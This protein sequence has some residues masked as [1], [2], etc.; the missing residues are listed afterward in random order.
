MTFFADKIFAVRTYNR[1]DGAAAKKGGAIW[2]GPHNARFPA[3]GCEACQVGLPLYEW[4]W[5]PPKFADRAVQLREIADE[6]ATAALAR[7]VER[8]AVSRA[9][10]ESVVATSEPGAPPDAL[11]AHEARA[12]EIRAIKLPVPEGLSYRP[13]QVAGTQFMLAADAGTI[14]GDEPGLGKTIQVI[15]LINAVGG[16]SLIV[17]PA[18]L[19]LNWLRECVRWLVEPKRIHVIG[20]ANILPRLKGST[21]PSIKVG[22]HRVSAGPTLPADICTDPQAIV[23]LNYDRA[24]DPELHE[25]LMACS[26]DTLAADEAH[27]LKTPKSLRTIA[28]LGREEKGELVQEGLRQRAG[29]FIAMTGTPLPN[30]P[31]E[32]WPILH[33]VAPKTFPSFFGFARRYCAA[34]KKY[35]SRRVGEKWDFTGSSNLDEL[36]NVMRSTCMVRR[37]K[38]DVLTELPPKI[39]TIIALPADDFVDLLGEGEDYEDRP[40]AW[41]D[42]ADWDDRPSREELDVADAAL[43]AIIEGEIERM[44]DKSPEAAYV[45]AAMLLGAGEKIDFK[46]MS[47]MREKLALRKLGAVLE[48]ADN[49]LEEEAKII[50]FAHHHS[51]VEKILD[52]YNPKPKKGKE[53]KVEA[54]AFYGP[55][56]ARDR[57]EAIQ[58]FQTDP[59]IRVFV[60]SIA[61][62]GVGITLTE[63]STVIF[64]EVSFVP[65]DIVQAEDRAHRIGQTKVVNVLHVVVE[66]S[67]DARMVQMLVKKAD[68]A[69]QA[70]DRQT[71]L[72]VP[73]AGLDVAGERK[74]KRA[75]ADAKL[76]P[77]TP[78]LRQLVQSAMQVLVDLDI[79]RATKVNGIGFNKMHGGIG[80][81]IAGASSP[82]ASQVWFGAFLA[83]FYRKQ[84]GGLAAEV[85][86]EAAR[87]KG[88]SPPPPTSPTTRKKAAAALPAG[89]PA[90]PPAAP[91]PALPA[92]P[93]AALVTAPEPTSDDAARAYAASELARRAAYRQEVAPAYQEVRVT[94]D[95]TPAP[96]L[97]A[98]AVT[99]ELAQVRRGVH[100][101]GL[102]PAGPPRM[103]AATGRRVSAS[104]LG[105]YLQLPEATVRATLLPQLVKLGVIGNKAGVIGNKAGAMQIDE[106]RADG[107]R[108]PSQQEGDQRRRDLKMLID[109]LNDIQ[110][111]ATDIALGASKR[112]E[113]TGVPEGEILTPAEQE[114][115]RHLGREFSMVREIMEKMFVV[116]WAERAGRAGQG[117]LN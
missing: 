93:A 24:R 67:L 14:L 12:M 7:R 39:R 87:I 3:S 106:S 76:P 31:V 94:A 65:G 2:H 72:V 38:A 34:H 98:L 71:V 88:E 19:R 81:S 47:K 115:L 46:S 10:G 58:R 55:M 110:Q 43:A 68:I 78:E 104:D 108:E 40:Q 77:V 4:W 15:A 66:R 23:I 105:S 61:A 13:Y 30:R 42:D 27:F 48:I 54:V 96:R 80:R 86:A 49:R 117:G 17:A 113:R 6:L 99:N 59:S 62:A 26:W 79:D 92:A 69:D 84:L 21:A 109:E 90:G 114:E 35:I 89:P 32:M 64:A 91:L 63:A 1:D 52:H 50:I 101:A 73:E 20:E 70:L 8:L 53:G 103:V 56:S 18:S 112:V 45:K 44:G 36:Q 9:V 41:D 29:R 95:P 60:G 37:K 22:P 51:V 33:A 74:R 75:E 83:N 82:T 102:P 25:Q 11:A 100:G 107:Y 28:V 5:Y 16:R 97:P 111:L 116:M 57:D 85:R